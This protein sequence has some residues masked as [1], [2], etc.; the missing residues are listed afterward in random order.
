M[1]RKRINKKFA[2]TLAGVVGGVAV[3]GAGAFFIFKPK[4]T[5]ER[6]EAMAQIAINDRN[7]EAAMTA[8]GR[9]VAIAPSPEKLVRFGDIARAAAAMRPDKV[10]LRNRDRAA[11]ERALEM[12]PK[13]VPAIQKL[14]EIQQERIRAGASLPQEFTRMRELSERLVVAD[15]NDTRAKLLIP[16]SHIQEWQRPGFTGDIAVVEKAIEELR[17]LVAT[18]SSNVD[19]VIVLTQAILKRGLETLQTGRADAKTEASKAFAEANNVLDDALAKQD[20][21]LPLHI[22]AANLYNAL[23]QL[24]SDNAE[25]Y[26]KKVRS[27]IERGRTLALPEKQFFVDINVMAANEALRSRGREPADAIYRATL[28]QAPNSQALRLQYA[29]F[30]S[31]DVATRSKAIELLSKPIEPDQ[32][33]NSALAGQRL[34]NLT[35]ATARSLNAYRL[36]EVP[37]LPDKPARDAMLAKIEEDVR[38][39][40]VERSD[41]YLALS[42]QGRLLVLQGRSV[43]AVQSFERARTAIERT[44]GEQTTERPELVTGRLDIMLRLSDAY[45]I[46]GQTGK[47]RDLIREVVSIRP[48][49][50]PGRAQLV[51][52]L[53][54]E[55][56]TEAARAEFLAARAQMEKLA[57]VENPENKSQLDLFRRAIDAVG[58]RFADSEAGVADPIAF[59]RRMPES[60]RVE[61]VR[62]GTA[63]LQI[64]QYA[65]ASRILQVDVAA[66]PKDVEAA[67]L[68]VN[69]LSLDGKTDQAREVLKQAM[70]A[71]P[72]D[73]RLKMLDVRLSG[74][75]VGDQAKLIEDEIRKIPDE[76][77]R[78]MQLY[79]FKS[80]RGDRPGA[81]THFIRA[82]QLNPDDRQVLDQ[83]FQIALLEKDWATAD[84][85]LPK[86]VAI[87][88]AGGAEIGDQAGGNLYRFRLAQARGNAADAMSIATEISLQLPTFALS[89][90]SL[91]QANAM[92]GNHERALANFEQA[93]QFKPDER[94]ALLGA[95]DA[96]YALNRLD[97]AKKYIDL[98]RTRIP[99]DPTLAQAET[100]HN[101]RFGDPDAAVAT[102]EREIERLSGAEREL[103]LKVN[104]MS[105]GPEQDKLRADLASV[106]RRLGEVLAQ[107]GDGYFRLAAGRETKGDVAGARDAIAKSLAVLS[108]AS[109]KLP[110]ELAVMAS[111]ARIAPM[112]PNPGSVEPALKRTADAPELA[113]RPEPTLILA[114]YYLALGRADEAEKSIREAVRRGGTA[115]APRASA[116]QLLFRLGKVDD[117]LAVLSDAENAAGNKDLQRLRAELLVSSGR[118]EQA[119]KSL[120]ALI[121]QTPEDAGLSNLLARTLIFGNRFDDAEKTIEGVLAREPQNPAALYFRGLIQV[122]KPGGDLNA[123]IRDLRAVRDAARLSTDERM[124]LVEALMRNGDQ[125]NAIIELRDLVDTNPL[126]K[127][128]RLQLADL[129]SRTTP[130]R[131]DEARRVVE[132]GLSRPEFANDPDLL[133]TK[134]RIQLGLG[135]GDGAVLSSR[136]AVKSSKSAPPAVRAY[137][138]TLLAAKQGT[139]VLRETEDMAKSGFKAWWALAAR[140][141]AKVQLNDQVGAVNEY[142]AA[143]QA[144]NDANDEEGTTRIPSMM[145]QSLGAENAIKALNPR[146]DENVL[147]RLMTAQLQATLGQLPTSLATLEPA[148]AKVDTLKPVDQE[149]L[150]RAAANLL[151]A[152]GP[153][154]NFDRAADLYR[155]LVKLAPNDI[156][157]LNNLSF[158]IAERITSPNVAEALT[159]SERAVELIRRSG[160]VEPL[161]YDTHGWNLVL[162][163]RIPE[164]ID[165]LTQALDRRSFMEGHYHLG[166]AYLKFNLPREAMDQ[167]E[168]ADR[169]SNQ[170]GADAS[171]KPKI[172]EAI[173]QAAL[174]M[175]KLGSNPSGNRR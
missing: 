28:D 133:M 98:G 85:V 121:Q 5:P 26:T 60:T 80:Q 43:D 173:N 167:L 158:I 159:Y 139:Q 49:Y 56:N 140:A 132:V 168:R 50:I 88:K 166:M 3:L 12:D 113:N 162:N 35:A 153:Q 42:L 93:L 125:N 55:G 4:D 39:M 104:S 29:E 21:N 127:V 163:N 84:R 155:K 10:E 73:N 122:R 1:A 2:L 17:T 75:S 87:S 68:L 107:A 111:L 109:D 58:T 169:A 61:R 100:A 25:S 135:D 20:Q 53:F 91:G 156:A 106:S 57:A 46:A 136:E 130:P 54:R 112:N 114:Q 66:D 138:D 40:L 116:A 31:K 161:V 124:T 36:D 9:S 32:G 110:T 41:D 89:W 145:A 16:I 14:V 63:A 52:L 172:A 143:L 134:S 13:Y 45:R 62:K 78:E 33:D 24:D 108:R 99:G 34:A 69:A 82:E 64:K 47:Q 117:A 18:D 71:N 115:P 128:L 157:T 22:Q 165:L 94:A 175:E 77:N 129:L 141:A 67:G 7:F 86:L 154:Q 81:M 105:P 38:R 171:F 149:R 92:N 148:L 101:L 164:G 6:L 27:T 83:R 30:L 8:F 97:D 70:A 11:Y 90:V 95:V 170:P 147:Y 142:S 150:L 119:E 79:L 37:T 48:D 76:F 123:A 19:A 137:L 102:F 23:A 103:V 65:D 72:D 126:N 160:Q 51:E 59:L 96:N 174:A 144:A 44:M 118:Y 146:L 120:R 15:P 152:P 131:L 151:V 74:G